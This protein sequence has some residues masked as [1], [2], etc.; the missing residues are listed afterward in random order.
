MIRKI[1]LILCTIE[2]LFL[3]CAT[4]S[5]QTKETVSP[6]SYKIYKSTISRSVGKLRRLVIMP[7]NYIF[8]HDGKR[9]PNKEA[10]ASE[11]MFDWAAQFLHDWR[12][13]EVFGYKE[14]NTGLTEDLSSSLTT[15]E[16]SLKELYDWVDKSKVDLKLPEKLYKFIESAGSQ[17]KA[18]GILVLQGYQKPPSSWVVLSVILSASL[19]WP[20]LFVDMEGEL[21]AEIIGVHTGCLLWKSRMS[22]FDASKQ[23]TQG[24]FNR[25]LNPIENAVPLV[26]IE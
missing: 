19:T 15:N 6:T 22:L 2:S 21:K 16:D 9:E 10:I 23:L 8:I 14:P 11:H 17:S 24:E 4:K 12:G 20:L 3:G 26:L 1:I 7:A 5:Q 18:D 13:Y 25:L